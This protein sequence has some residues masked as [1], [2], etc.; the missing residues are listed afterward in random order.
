MTEHH[1]PTHPEPGADRRPGVDYA[2]GV[3]V[4]VRAFV[5]L[6]DFA[7]FY[8]LSAPAPEPKPFGRFAALVEALGL[9]DWAR[10]GPWPETKKVM[11]YLYDVGFPAPPG[12]TPTIKD[13]VERSV[14]QDQEA[15]KRG[16]QVDEEDAP[17]GPNPDDMVPGPDVPRWSYT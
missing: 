6:P 14:A 2:P 15:R 16:D 7:S 5:K 12:T 9:S 10:G 11:G 4:D 13:L 3:P 17:E 1:P 8:R